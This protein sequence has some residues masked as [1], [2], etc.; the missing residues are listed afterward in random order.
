MSN[1]ETLWTIAHQ[2]PLCMGFFRQEYWSGL[3][4]PSPGDLPDLGIKLTIPFLALAG[5]F[6]TSSAT[7]K[8]H[9]YTHIHIKVCVCIRAGDCVSSHWG[10]ERRKQNFCP[11][12]QCCRFQ[13]WQYFSLS[14]LST[15]TLLKIN[16]EII[17]LLKYYVSLHPFIIMD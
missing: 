1:S 7:W 10:G 13:G 9:I 4:F 14:K 17:Y 5:R 12:Y 3:P 15:K 6:F 2:A 16:F 11:F 8:A